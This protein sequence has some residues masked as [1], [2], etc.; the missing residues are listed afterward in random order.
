MVE[1]F[2]QLTI[3]R[4]FTAADCEILAGRFSLKTFEADEVI[5]SQNDTVRTLF[6][7]AG[8]RVRSALKLPG[9]DEPKHG[10]YLPGDFFGELSLFGNKPSFDTY[11][12]AERSVLLTVGEED[13]TALVDNN[14]DTGVK[15][16]SLLVSLSIEKLRKS[17]KFLADVVQWGENA[18]RRVI[19]DELTGV[20]NRAFLDDALENFFNASKSNNK[21]LSLL[22]LD[23]DVF[24]VIN[25]TLGYETANDVLRAVVDMIKN[26][27][28]QHG[29][30]ARYG[31][32]EFSILLPEA[33]LARAADIAERMRREV[34]S[35]DFSEYLGGK[36]IRVTVSIGISAFPETA[37]DLDSFKEKADASLYRAKEEGRNRTVYLP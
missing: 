28:S 16:I 15:L 17:S 34:E 10:Q 35:Q 24:R 30:I 25:E 29:I 27:I 19:T 12:A 1:Y 14:P 6:I 32:D 2:R 4:G 26:S 20:Y 36:R 23:V 3:F 18:S 31:G 5:V 13:I 8:G 11:S 21:P 33:G 37:R 7:V 9:S 22:M